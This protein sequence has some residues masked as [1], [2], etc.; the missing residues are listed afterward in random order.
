MMRRVQ[1]SVAAITDNWIPP[2][3]LSFPGW[4]FKPFWSDFPTAPLIY[5]E[6]MQEQYLAYSQE[7]RGWFRPHEDE[8]MQVVYTEREAAAF[9][10]PED[11]EALILK[12]KNAMQ[13]GWVI[14]PVL[15]L[16]VYD[17]TPP[18]LGK[19]S[20]IE[21][22]MRNGDDDTDELPPQPQGGEG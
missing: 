21:P 20:K 13:E 2:Q 4:S 22:Q 1:H 7:F 12:R 19:V 14:Q 3:R 16:G 18:Q 6:S 15:V 11:A 5:G 10:N 8:T 9:V 17:R